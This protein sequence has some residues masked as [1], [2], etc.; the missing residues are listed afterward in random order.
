[1]LI[2]NSKSF[3][4]GGVFAMTFLSVL[5]LIFSPV[6]KGKNG[7]QFADNTFNRLSKGSSYFIPKIGRE[8]SQF[9]GRPFSVSIKLNTSEEADIAEKLLSTAGAYVARKDVDLRLDGDLGRVLKSVLE[10]SDAMYNNHGEAVSA[11]Y[12]YDEK[13]VMKIWWTALAKIEKKLKKEKEIEDSKIVSEVMKKG[14]EPAYNFYHIE[15]EKVVDHAGMMSGLLVF[16]V[17]YTMW[18]GYAIYYLFEGLGLT[19]KKA[20]LKKED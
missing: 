5:L 14:V 12:G 13:Q 17:A 20:R 4:V 2:K 7:L 6:F 1:M 3:G 8:V 10:D 16:Y 11:R 9:A 18:W 19:M 15:D